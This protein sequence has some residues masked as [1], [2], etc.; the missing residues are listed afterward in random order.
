VAEAKPVEEYQK[1]YDLLSPRLMQAVAVQAQEQADS[2]LLMFGDPDSY[3]GYRHMTKATVDS[4]LL[5]LVTEGYVTVTEEWNITPDELVVR[6][7]E[8]ALNTTPAIDSPKGG[9]YV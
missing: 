1:A 4:F 8:K 5:W 2:Y 7:A 3:R 6:E 9:G